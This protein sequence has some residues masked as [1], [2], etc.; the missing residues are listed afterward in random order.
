M[1]NRI[2]AHLGSE[3]VSRVIYG[4]IIG[5]ALIVV[6]EHHPPTAGVTTATL[7]ATAVA[8][9]LAELYSDGSDHVLQHRTGFHREQV[10]EIAED[11]G[12]VAFGIVFPGVFFLLAT[13]GGSRSTPRSRWRSGAGVGLITLYGYAAGRLSGESRKRS[14]LQALAVSR[15]RDRADRLQGAGALAARSGPGAGRCGRA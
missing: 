10:I 5:M 4:A 11:V 6:L 8:V 12:A 7:F 1:G 3:Q 13:F 14:A 15:D 2:E 9:A